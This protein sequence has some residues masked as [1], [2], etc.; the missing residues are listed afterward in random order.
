MYLDCINK[1]LKLLNNARKHSGKCVNVLI[2][3]SN[4][5]KQL[6]YIYNIVT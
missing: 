5:L 4:L 6:N 2:V 3:A 1:L